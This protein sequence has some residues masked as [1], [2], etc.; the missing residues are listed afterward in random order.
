MIWFVNF[1]KNF[2]KK[3]LFACLVVFMI[4]GVLKS[5][6][7]ENYL[8][9][10]DES[11]VLLMFNTNLTLRNYKNH[12][13]IYNNHIMQY[14]SYFI[15]KSNNLALI[16]GL[17]F[18]DDKTVN[19]ITVDKFKCAIQ[20]NNGSNLIYINATE[21]YKL[22]YQ[23]ILKV[24]CK[25][26]DFYN[27]SSI[28][29]AIIYNGDYE[30]L[31]R[32]LNVYPHEMINFQNADLVV[33]QLPRKTAVGVCLNYVSNVY[34][35]ILSWIEIHKDF[36]VDKIIMH[37]GSSKH[38]LKDLVYSKFSSEFVEIRMYNF[39]F[40][41][42]CNT[43][44][45]KYFKK[46]YSKYFSFY[47]KNC[48]RFYSSKFGGFRPDLG[49]HNHLTVNDCY[50]NYG[51]IYEFVTLYDLD[52]LIVPRSLNQS[53]EVLECN[54]NKKIC[55]MSPF[56]TP[57]YDYLKSL[58]K[59]YFDHDITKLR[60]IAFEHAAY[61]IPNE[62]EN[63]IMKQIDD[64]AKMIEIKNENLNFPL[65]INID[66]ARFLFFS[67]TRYSFIIEET[68]VDYVVYIN[69]IYQ[70]IKCFLKHFP[71]SKQLIDTQ[72]IRFLYFLPPSWQ[73]FPKSIH[74]TQNV[75]SLFTHNALNF[76]QDS[77]ILKANA[78]H[79]HINSH[80]RLDLSVFYR[81][82]LEISIKNLAIDYEYFIYLI[83]NFSDYC[84]EVY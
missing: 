34:D 84:Q 23:Y 68:D 6:I 61:F 45:I 5:L 16:E 15:K 79:A 83:E 43:V 2:S 38:S 17:V 73:R 54:G 46:K 57:I 29:V 62:V 25:Y 1:R 75:K 81:K 55:N 20:Q 12:R 51:Y 65:K 30:K 59:N 72:F 31:P 18:V 27:K 82:N 50:A 26:E 9:N 49:A 39:E 19:A 28:S 71:K 56:K 47:Y 66:T 44:E 11:N 35:G 13:W 80:F 53:N 76:T 77:I 24:V 3:H 78:Q 8:T 33:E 52:E 14:S 58:V 64:A 37:D 70:M 41:D 74:Y 36:K 32:S 22:V 10:D 69:R 40:N 42:I 63:M 48:K 21:I 4:I 67:K 7:D 60:S